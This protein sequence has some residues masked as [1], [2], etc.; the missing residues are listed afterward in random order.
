MW[1]LN[2]IGIKCA[3]QCPT[4]I[5]E[6]HGWIYFLKNQTRNLACSHGISFFQGTV[7][8][9]GSD[10]I[11]GR[12]SLCLEN[13]IKSCSEGYNSVI[14]EVN[15]KYWISGIQPLKA[16]DSAPLLFVSSFR[17]VEAMIS[18]KQCKESELCASK[19][20]V[21]LRNSTKDKSVIIASLCIEF[22]LVKGL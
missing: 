19:V 18:S 3:P 9:G 6:I 11:Q 20:Y 5:R 2:S 13:L 16:W 1:Q 10:K 7:W 17:G 14:L 22:L 12:K 15:C 4:N 8:F 21:A